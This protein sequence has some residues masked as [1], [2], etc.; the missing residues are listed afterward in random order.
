MTE[1]VYLDISKLK[2]K[3]GNDIGLGLFCDADH[4]F[5]KGD[6]ICNYEA[7]LVEKAIT[8]EPDYD[9]DYVFAINRNWAID[10]KDELSF[11]RYSNDPIDLRKINCK[12]LV[13]KKQMTI[14]YRAIRKIK[15]DEEIY[16]SY[17]TDYWTEDAKH[18]G[19]LSDKQLEF[20]QDNVE[21]HDEQYQQIFGKR[22]SDKKYNEI[23]N[24]DDSDSD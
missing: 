4:T 15:P 1:H 9:T 17:G 2:G 23:M 14:S 13:N 24:E 19:L 8:D 20:L 11:G 18:N 22:M 3:D 6:F 7:T 16:V 5:E 21:M 12:P 10:G